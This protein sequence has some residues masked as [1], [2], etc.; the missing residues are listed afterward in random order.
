MDGLIC[1]NRLNG[2]IG[3]NISNGSNGLIGA[4]DSKIQMVRIGYMQVA[5]G[6]KGLNWL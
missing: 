1:L 4:N 3:S 6:S 2:L 5:I